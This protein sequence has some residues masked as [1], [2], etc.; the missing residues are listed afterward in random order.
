MLFTLE[1]HHHNFWLLKHATAILYIFCICH[2]AHLNTC[3]QQYTLIFLLYVCIRC[4]PHLNQ[5]VDWTGLVVFV[6]ISPKK[7]PG[8][9]EER[10]EHTMVTFTTA[11]KNG[12]G[13]C[14]QT[15][16]S[17]VTHPTT[18]RHL[19]CYSI[20][21]CSTQNSTPPIAKQVAYIFF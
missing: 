11:T 21:R 17:T 3:T 6:R 19:M 14:P 13:R 9:E 18:L 10:L 15:S 20:W 4:A 1:K 2:Y 7:G 5:Q 12:G 8:P 16:Q